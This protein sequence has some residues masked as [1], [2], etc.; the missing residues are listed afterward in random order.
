MDPQALIL[1]L[2]FTMLLVLGMPVAFALGISTFLAVLSIGQVPAPLQV[3]RVMASGIDSFPLLAIPFFV[4]AGELMSGGGMAKRLLT[5]AEAMVGG[6]RGG[7]AYVNTVTCMMFGAISGSAAVPN[8]PV[9]SDARLAGDA[10]QTR[11]ILDL[12]K[13]V[14]FR[15]FALADPYRVVVDLP[16]LSF[17]L[18]AGVETGTQMRLAGKGQAGPGGG[19]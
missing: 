18:P 7:L 5:F 1:I 13:P 19:R 3:S 16:Q 6:L 2:A 11:F 4:V 17:K 9:A 14:Q 15:A 8:F 10:R 12:D